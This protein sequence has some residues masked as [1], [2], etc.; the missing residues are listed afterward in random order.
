MKQLFLMLIIIVAATFS[1]YSQSVIVNEMSQGNGGKKEWVEL[2]VVDNNVDMRGWELGD[3]DDGVWN[4]IVTFSNAPQWQAVKSGTLIVIFNQ[5]E[6]D[7]V[8]TASGSDDT[9]FLDFNVTIAADNITFFLDP[10]TGIGEFL[11]DDDDDCAAIRDASDVMVHDMAVTHAATDIATVPSPNA[12]QTKYFNAGSV[13]ATV[14][15]ANWTIDAA[16]NATPGQPNG[17]INT[18]WIIGLRNVAIAAVPLA[19]W[20]IFL[21]IGFIVLFGL[22][23]RY[24]FNIIKKSE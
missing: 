3:N 15:D 17:G 18:I 6:V 8:I 10:W 19:L 21:S 9:N 12:F 23:K 4:S 13:A 16:N 14:S 1:T 5:A 2:L 24:Y 20:P 7:D 11:N 22:T